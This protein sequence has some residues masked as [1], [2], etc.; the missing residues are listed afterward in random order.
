MSDLIKWSGSKDSQSKN[1][2]GYFPNEID[3]YY[4]PFIGGGSIFLALLESDIKINNYYL[5][6]INKELIGIYELIKNEPDKIIKSYKSHYMVFNQVEVAGL[7][8]ERRKDYF[9]FIRSYFN[10]N[11][12]PEDLYWIMR[13][14]TNGMPRYNK[15]GEFNNSC[16]FSRPGMNPDDV[17]KLI[18]KYHKLF[19]SKNINFNCISYNTKFLIN[20][21][22]INDLVYCDPPYENTKGMYFGGFDNKEFLE[23]INNLG[24]KW[25]LSYDGKVNSSKVEHTAPKFKRHEYLISGNSSFRRVIGNSNDSIVSESLY[26]NF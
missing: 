6:D 10:K 21:P 12:N 9:K 2:L 18:N 7:D 11:K 13:T 4:E 26:L 15:K 3:S 16:H 20:S 22:N 23:W 1:I 25:V 5:S 14:T 19:N 24:C 8:I 17:E